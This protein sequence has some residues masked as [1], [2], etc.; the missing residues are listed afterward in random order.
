[1]PRNHTGLG[2]LIVPGAPD[3]KVVLDISEEQ[4]RGWQLVRGTLTGRPEDLARAFENDRHA[5]L[6]H[7]ATG[8]RMSLTIA[9]VTPEGLAHVTVDVSA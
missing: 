3:A 7:D 9:D 6:V 1:M 5:I 4:E 8:F 2:T